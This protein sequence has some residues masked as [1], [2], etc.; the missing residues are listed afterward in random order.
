MHTELPESVNT[1]FNST[2]YDRGDT[3]FTSPNYVQSDISKNP[4]IGLQ[5]PVEEEESCVVGENDLFRP[6]YFAHLRNLMQLNLD[7]LTDLEHL[8]TISNLLGSSS[9]LAERS[10]R[11]LSKIDLPIFRIISHSDRFLDIVTTN[12]VFKRVIAPGESPI[13]P[14]ELSTSPRGGSCSPFNDLKRIEDC[15]D[16]IPKTVNSDDGEYKI[17]S[18]VPSNSP[19][20]DGLS[21][22]DSSEPLNIL[23]A[24]CQLIRLYHTLFNQLHRLFLMVPPDEVADILSLPTFRFGK[25][26]MVGDFTAKLQVLI[27]LSF[28]MLGNIDHALGIPEFA[29]GGF[30]EEMMYPSQYIS[31]TAN[32][33]IST[34]TCSSL[35]SLR[36]H[37]V[38]REHVMAGQSLRET[39]HF[40]QA[41]VKTI[42]VHVVP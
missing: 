8:E 10:D 3:W 27:E 38:T 32:S 6:S 14:E 19:G 5:S 31:F 18:D 37:V 12:N 13:T 7:L 20:H 42:T 4:A 24:Y 30:G 23:A 29:K 16:T 39:M 41:F 33:T 26:H 25:F 22:S 15:L 35:G 28:Y 36:D 9:I 40:L 1:E 2:Q 21:T 11:I 34:S 17:L